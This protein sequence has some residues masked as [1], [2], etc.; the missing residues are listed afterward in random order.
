METLLA[1]TIGGMISAGVYLLLGRSLLRVLLGIALV[2]D[3][4]NLLIL[5]AGRL[6]RLHPPLIES[7]SAAPDGMVANPL[8]QAL[9]L[10][11]VVI[12]FGILILLLAL[13]LRG[14]HEFGTF[15]TDRWRLTEP[16]R[17][18]DGQP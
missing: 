14:L 9:I 7:G 3:A 12:T 5:T 1:I 2:S 8:P 17:P 13:A 4:V 11:A 10:T 18:E 15:D 16:S 6:T